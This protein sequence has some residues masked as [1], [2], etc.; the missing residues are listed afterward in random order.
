MRV[1]EIGLSESDMDMFDAEP[2]VNRYGCK[3]QLIITV[4]GTA[5]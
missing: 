3:Y 1:D 4:T 5:C 2:L